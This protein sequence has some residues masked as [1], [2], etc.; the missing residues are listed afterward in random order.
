[1]RKIY[2]IV[3]ERIYQDFSDRPVSSTEYLM[4]KYEGNPDIHIS[5]TKLEKLGI[6]PINIF[7][8]PLGIYTYQ[9]KEVLESAKKSNQPLLNKI[10]DFVDFAGDQPWVWIMEPNFSQGKFIDDITNRESYSQKD[11]DYDLRELENLY[12]QEL[13][14]RRYTIED[15]IE[16]GEESEHSYEWGIESNTPGGL[17]WNIVKELSILIAS[18][19]PSTMSS[20]IFKELG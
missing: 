9:L 2:K 15:L 19:N 8:T 14:V 3:N 1:M 6:N 12:G 17:F 11:F 13:D 10:G 4:H 7:P 18:N 20:S 16:L 5:F